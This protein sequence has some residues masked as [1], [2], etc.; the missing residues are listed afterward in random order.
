MNQTALHKKSENY[1]FPFMLSLSKGT[2]PLHAL[3]KDSSKHGCY[4]GLFDELRVSGWIYLDFL[5]KA[6]F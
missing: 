3:S 5:C 4:S 2:A 1:P 6:C